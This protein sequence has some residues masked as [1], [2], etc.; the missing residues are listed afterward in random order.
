MTAQEMLDYAF[1]LLDEPRRITCEREM[2]AD[3]A[4]FQRVARLG[5]S[6]ATLVDDGEVIEP[7][8]GL[9][10]R[11]LATVERRKQK[12]QFQDFVP[13]RVPFRWADV[14]VA[15]TVFFASI[16][17]LTVPLLQARAKMGQT[18]CAFNL[19]KLGVS[20]AKY[21]STHGNYPF[22]PASYPVGTYGVMLQES[23]NL[24]DPSILACPSA[25]RNQNHP[26]LP[27]YDR[28]RRLLA[29][30]PKS[31][32]AML[33]GHFA[34]N[35]GYR[36]PSGEAVPVPETPASLMP[37]ASDGPACDSQGQ[38]LDGN[39]PNH[40]GH[41]QN[42]LFTD[43][44][45]SWRRNRWVSDLDRDIFLNNANRPAAGLHSG[46]SALIPSVMPVSLR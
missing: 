16:L 17:T 37:I 39:S 28:F 45:V 14:A 21:S 33:E 20:L 5:V 4:L 13:T 34:Y 18:A 35:V 32:N 12:P 38:I 9:A 2:A 40:G 36:R 26:P 46:D 7:P 31:C 6:I 23:S 27:D 1:G 42:V 22:V 10:V 25:I 19:G 30:S 24:P 29:E 8:T 15:A 11:A 3:P 44:H 41:G 43:G